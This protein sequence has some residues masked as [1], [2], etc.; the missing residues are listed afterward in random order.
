[1]PVGAL[2]YGCA[3]P[4]HVR[5]A[6]TNLDRAIRY[7]ELTAGGERFALAESS[8]PI[9]HVPLGA[10]VDVNSTIEVE[11]DTNTIQVPGAYTPDRSAAMFGEARAKKLRDVVVA[12][13]KV[14]AVRSKAVAAFERTKSVP[15][16]ELDD[17]QALQEFNDAVGE[18]GKIR[19]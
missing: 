4:Q 8:G 15:P 5:Q 9:T 3:S 17:S 10:E 18:F 13:N 2:L 14:I 19:H 11:I 6:T 12:V 1:M 7:T 16:Q